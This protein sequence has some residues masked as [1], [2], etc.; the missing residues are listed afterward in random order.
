MTSRTLV[1]PA[2]VDGLVAEQATI[3]QTLEC[4]LSAVRRRVVRITAL[5][6][7]SLHDFSTHPISR[8]Q[9]TLVGGERLPVI[10]KRLQPKPGKEVG[11]EVGVYRRVLAGRRF[12]APELYGA[13]ADA[14]TGRYWLF[15]E[16]VGSWRLDYCDV[17]TWRTAFRWLA[18]MHGWSLGRP[19][20]LTRLGCAQHD[21]SF[22]RQL[23]RLTRQ[24]LAVEAEPAVV[25][26]FDQLVASGLDRAVAYLGRQPRA[27]LHGDV[28]CRNLMVQAE[29]RIRPVDWEWAAVGLPGWDLVRLLSGWDTAPR[30]QFLADYLGALEPCLS[31]R[32]DHRLF[33]R[34]LA[35]CEA[36][37]S[38]WYLRW[39]V[40]ACR[41]PAYVDRQLDRI[42]AAWREVPDD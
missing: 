2:V 3:R 18:R 25:T 27:L 16:D 31:H 38:L 36:L 15:L 42:E 40:A 13:V 22:Y 23:T 24:T 39:W 34:T 9:V 21:A 20:R 28:S 32:L 11:Q 41:D 6:R 26:R 10:F 14:T 35:Q 33:R 30:D 12:D 37:Q 17:D 19:A 29:E 1:A 4:G 7:D 8:L 5:E